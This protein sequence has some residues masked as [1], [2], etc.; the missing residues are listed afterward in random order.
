[1]RQ[2]CQKYLQWMMI[3]ETYPVANSSFTEDIEFEDGPTFIQPVVV[4]SPLLPCKAFGQPT[5]TLSWRFQRKKIP[6]GQA[7]QQDN[8]Y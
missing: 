6:K 8:D 7:R 2:F 3:I 4:A 5:P 1:M